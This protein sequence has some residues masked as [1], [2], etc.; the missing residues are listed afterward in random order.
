M[1][2]RDI[3]LNLLVVLHEVLAT[4]HVSRA[5][6]NLDMSQPAVSNALNRLRKILGDDLFL[7][8]SKGIAPT[9]FAEN[10][11]EPVAHALAMMHD[12]VNM[13]TGFDPATARREFRVAL[14][15]VGEIYF[16]PALL[17]LLAQAGPG[18]TIS[19]VRH[20]SVDLRE[21]MEKGRVDLALGVFPHLQFGFFQRRLFAQG[22]VCLLRRGHPLAG[23][24]LSLAAFEAAQHISVTAEGTGHEAIEEALARTGIV[25]DIRLRVPHFV[26][27]GH[28]LNSS[29]L[30]AVVPDA[31][32]RRAFESSDLV[33]APCPKELVL[34]E[35]NINLL[36]HA[37]NHRDPGDQ[38]LRQMI[39][40]RFSGDLET[41]R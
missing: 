13:Q 18:I 41:G 5:A 40:E 24:P 33:S 14:T 37:Q 10:M 29:D 25:R 23:R 4:G 39:F 3:D 35:I 8:T 17:P 27:V 7:R 11:R 21:E 19:S 1:K 26:A 28:V 31:F 15:D 12:A 16:L 34:P 30:I 9:R 22:Y 38:W 20:S 32:A 36:W 2:L 6:E